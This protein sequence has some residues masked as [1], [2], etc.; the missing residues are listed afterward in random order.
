VAE[1]LAAPAADTRRTAA[2]YGRI[3][4]SRLRSQLTYRTSFVLDL[5]AQAL[6]QTI[7]LFSILV[8]FTQVDSLGGFADREV[9][10][11]FGLAACAFGLADLGVGQ[12]ERLPDYIRTGEFDV[13]LLRP[14]GALPQ[15]LCAD[16][17][18][19]RLGRVGVGLAVYG[20]SLARLDVAWTPLRA[21]IAV[22]APLVGAVILGALWVAANAVSFWV[23]D[24]R[25]VA[26]AVTYGS[27][28]STSYPITVY[29]PWL[30]RAMCFAVPGAFVAYFPALALLDRPDPLGLPTGLRY[31]SPVVA[32]VAVAAAALVWRLG[33]RRYQ[34]TGS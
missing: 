26:N 15:L 31:A 6:G 24:G 12:V 27:N 30:R 9:V 8:V 22:T 5:A 2:V 13:I 10:L 23:V 29:G 34:G 3:V 18:L 32:A 7:E 1:L 11:I 4:G 25:E 33:V 19:K 14:L 17:A 20:W 21:L 28:F 16:I